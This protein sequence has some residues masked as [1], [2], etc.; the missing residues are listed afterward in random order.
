MDQVAYLNITNTIE[1]TYKKLAILALDQSMGYSLGRGFSDIVPEDSILVDIDTVNELKEMAISEDDPEK[2][3]RIE[4]ALMAC[5]DLTLELD[6]SSLSDMQRFYMDKGR[7]VVQ[8]QKIPALEIVPWLQ[9]Q[10]NYE[11]REEMTSELGIFSRAILN[12]IFLSILDV[13]QKTVTEKFGFSGYS[14]YAQFKRNCSFN[15]WQIIFSEYQSST[16]KVYFEK[17]SIWVEEKLGHPLEDLNR[18][19]AL[20]L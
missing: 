7:M 12:P 3:E 8:G 14:E 2:R 10:N 17:T 9:N 20:R 13:I 1:R 16:D 15:D 18:S 6:T 11:L 19:H 5:M 4:R